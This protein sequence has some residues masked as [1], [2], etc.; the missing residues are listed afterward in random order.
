MI[1]GTALHY[2][3]KNGHEALIQL[4]LNRKAD[5]NTRV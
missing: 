1:E 2:A 5:V 4:L 3:A